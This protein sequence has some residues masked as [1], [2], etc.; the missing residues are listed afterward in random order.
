[1]PNTTIG[2]RRSVLVMSLAGEES[3]TLLDMGGADYAF[4]KLKRWRAEGPT[5]RTR[6]MAQFLIGYLAPGWSSKL[7]ERS[8]LLVDLAL[9]WADFTM[10]QE[11]LKK[12]VKEGHAPHLDTDT[13]I[14]ACGV[15]TFDRTQ[16]MLVQSTL[17]P[18]PYFP[19]LRFPSPRRIEGVIRNEPNTKAAVDLIN[20]LQVHAS[21]QPTVKKWLKQ[22][23]TAVFSSIKSPPDVDDVSMFVSVAKSAGILFFS[24][25]Y[26][27]ADGRSV[28]LV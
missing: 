22:Q 25:T 27:P 20:G 16:D 12:S 7:S 10:W 15:F 21:G 9:G 26:V 24:K 5:E 14:R 11:T 2:Y 13:L 4:K 6:K 1:M 17:A 28:L 18:I 23:T 8:L 3:T 19:C